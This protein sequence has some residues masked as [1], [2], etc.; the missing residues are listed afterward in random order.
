MVLGSVKN[1]IELMKRIG[2]LKG[3]G[4]WVEDDLTER[5]ER[6]KEWL[7]KIEEEQAKNGLN[8]KIGYIQTTIDR[9]DGCIGGMKKRSK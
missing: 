4:W 5:Q 8:V 3:T 7:V 6:M 9:K 2:V 1:K